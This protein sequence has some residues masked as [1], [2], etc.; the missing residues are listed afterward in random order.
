MD[1]FFKRKESFKNDGDVISEL[2]PGV[3]KLF[4]AQIVLIYM[5]NKF[6]FRLAFS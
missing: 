2:W 5:K 3:Y 4:L 6:N 1:G